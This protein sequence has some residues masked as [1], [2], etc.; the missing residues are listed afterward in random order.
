M[1]PVNVRYVVEDVDVAV[2]FYT[3]YLGFTLLSKTAPHLPMSP[4]AISARCS[5]RRA[6][7][8][9][10]RCPTVAARCPEDGIGYSSW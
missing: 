6:V 9:G 8:R 4:A 5:A 3:T 2:N 7:Q 1:A 10:A